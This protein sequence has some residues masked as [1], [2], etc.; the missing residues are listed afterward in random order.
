MNHLRHDFGRKFREL[1]SGN[2]KINMRLLRG[3]LILNV[4]RLRLRDLEVA[5][6]KSGWSYF[7]VIR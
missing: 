6:L 4:N 5:A 1:E 3:I 7:V 2:L